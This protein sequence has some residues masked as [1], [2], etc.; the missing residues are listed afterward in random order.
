GS[1]GAPA[2]PSGSTRSRLLSDLSVMFTGIVT[3]IGE[4]V[5]ARR[6]AEGLVR[7]A[8][9]CAYD[10]ASI[11]LGA[12]VA[13]AGICLTVVATRQDGGRPVVEVDAAAET[14]A[15]TTAGR[16]QAG[17]RINLERP[18]RLGD[19]LGGHLVTGHVDG[20]AEI[21]AREDLT[22]MARLA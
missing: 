3:D 15:L 12:S 13:C 22:D 8:I 10:Q 18:L 1:S 17:T 2:R 21:I 14:L 6:L 5:E 11:P 9:G 20:L 7:F 16:W 19:E 4:V